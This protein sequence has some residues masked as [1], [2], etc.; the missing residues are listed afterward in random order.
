LAAGFQH[1]GQM[2]PVALAARERAD[3]LLLV[4]ALEVEGRA[5]GARVH[6]VLA[7]LDDVVAAGDLLPD[8]LVRIERI[9]ALVDIA[10][11]HRLADGDRPRIGLLLP[12]DHPE[13]RRLAGAVRA[14][15]ADNAARRQLERQIVDQQPVAKPL[16]G[17]PPRSP[18]VAQPLAGGMT[19]CAVR[20]ALRRRPL[21]QFVI[22]L[23]ARLGLG[24]ARLRAGAIHSC[25]RSSA[26]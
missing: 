2:H 4:A 17:L 19:I 1:L 15:D 3:L 7:E 14:D 12:G 9:A 18:L 13:Q 23:D 20:R 26:F 11:M 10:Q 25:S 21:H 24:L 6:L 5:I 16:R 8:G 22:G